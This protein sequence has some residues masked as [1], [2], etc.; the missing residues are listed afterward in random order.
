MSYD[1]N[2]LGIIFI[3]EIDQKN[4]YKTI[5]YDVQKDE[6]LKIN[7]SGYFIL[8]II[9]DNPGI[10]FDELSEKLKLVEET[11]GINFLKVLNFLKKMVAQNIVIEHEN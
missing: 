5:A 9:D 7:K 11:K 6:L 2:P 1:I 8:K 3:P 4:G 10:S